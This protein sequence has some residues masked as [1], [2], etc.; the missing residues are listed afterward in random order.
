MVTAISCKGNSGKPARVLHH[1]VLTLPLTLVL[2][3]VAQPTL[4]DDEERGLRDDDVTPIEQTP[5]TVSK[6]KLQRSI[7]D[8]A[9][10]A[11]R[12]RDSVSALG[13]YRSLYE[14][15]PGNVE[16]V[17]GMSRSLRALGRATE[18]EAVVERALKTSKR[19]SS[20]LAEAGK[21]RLS[22]GKAMPAIDSLSRAEALGAQGWDIYTALGV[23][24]DRVGM[25]DQAEAR[26]QKALDLSPDNA[27]VLNNLALSRAQSGDLDKAIEHL[28]RASALP[29]A[30]PRMRQ[31]LALFLA[32]KGDMKAAEDLV[33]QDLPPK[34]VETNM[35]YYRQLRARVKEE[36]GNVSNL[37]GITPTIAPVS[38]SSGADVSKDE[39]RNGGQ[40]VAPGR[41]PAKTQTKVAAT[42]SQS[43]KVV[44]ATPLPAE[45][46]SASRKQVLAAAAERDG[47]S[48]KEPSTGKNDQISAA[49]KQTV[50]SIRDKVATGSATQTATTD[51]KAVKATG[52]VRGGKPV[53]QKET[54]QGNVK[55]QQ[56]AA[57]PKDG[58]AYRL[59]FGAF[60]AEE[61]AERLAEDLTKSHKE[62]LGQLTL[63]VEKTTIAGKGDFFRVVSQEFTDRTLGSE[64]CNSLKKSGVSCLLARQR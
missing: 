13:Y 21:V 39:I 12:K 57:K 28:R 47:S 16:V 60:R 5:R 2:L 58:A 50:G 38:N 64:S 3:L 8:A 35:A 7:L 11:E 1:Q 42:G 55:R 15:D 33:K 63:S 34:D 14:R 54:G 6:D 32:L 56:I 25:F 18:A 52:D 44:P 53:K 27:V 40:G 30:T 49:T 17:V 61:R 46:E 59:Q 62:I 26:Y 41:A 29:E 20:L 48:A 31:N 24:Y 43:I 45:Q 23:A 10:L 51:P 19:S 36:G 4:G 9:E 22:L 37:P